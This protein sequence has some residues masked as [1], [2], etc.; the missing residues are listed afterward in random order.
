[1]PSKTDDAPPGFTTLREELNMVKK[2][3]QDLKDGQGHLMDNLTAGQK[4][5]MEDDKNGQATLLTKIRHLE[6]ALGDEVRDG[7]G[8]ILGKVRAIERDL[9]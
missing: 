8:Q 6:L 7:Q 3:I 5:I 4:V 9:S 1:M 2:S